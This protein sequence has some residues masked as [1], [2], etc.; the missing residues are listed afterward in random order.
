MLDPLS[1]VMV[2][3]NARYVTC[4]L[5]FS[6]GLKEKKMSVLMEVKKLKR[7]YFQNMDTPSRL[8]IIF[9]PLTPTPHNT[10]L[11][12]WISLVS[13]LESQTPLY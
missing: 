10:P 3:Q 7:F 5:W 6:F 9:P 4:P 13:F 1:Q 12:I 11:T 8:C 2:V